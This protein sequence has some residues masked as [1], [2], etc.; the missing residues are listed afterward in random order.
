MIYSRFIHGTVSER[1]AAIIAKQQAAEANCD[2]LMLAFWSR[3]RAWLNRHN[4]GVTP[5]HNCPW[6]LDY[7][8][9]EI[10]HPSTDAVIGWRNCEHSI[11]KVPRY[12]K[13]P[14]EYN[15]KHSP[16]EV[17]ALPPF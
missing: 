2:W 7:G 13:C 17:T 1:R 11:H 4:N 9:F 6:C 10:Y 14:S 12:G 15:W 16:E 5:E 3:R 8:G